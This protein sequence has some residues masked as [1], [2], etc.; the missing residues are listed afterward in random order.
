[1]DARLGGDQ[2][3]G[4]RA[5]GEQQQHAFIGLSLSIVQ[6]HAQPIASH[7]ILDSIRRALRILASPCLLCCPSAVPVRL[8]PAATQH[9]CPVRR[10]QRQQRRRQQQQQQQITSPNLRRPSAQHW[11]LT[12]FPPDGRR[13]NGL[14]PHRVTSH[15]EQLESRDR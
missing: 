3:R 10:Q 6:K 13:E 7:L 14:D 8:L 15:N 5:G 11:T 1:M 2:E 12:F 9:I 4:M